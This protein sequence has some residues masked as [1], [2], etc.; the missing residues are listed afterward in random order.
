MKPVRTSRPAMM[1][2]FSPGFVNRVF[3]DFWGNDD[4][5]MPQ[6]SEFK[7][8]SEIIKTDSGYQVRVSLPGVKKDDMK[9]DLDG[10]LLTLSGER[11]SEHTENK[12]NVVRSEINYGRFSR[13]FT[14]TS[15]IDRSKIQADYADGMLT[16][17]LPVSEKATA[18]R[19]DI[20]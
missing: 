10:N 5:F 19:I 20:K 16:I 1:D 9:I 15:D 12:N 7:P 17:D 6:L 14:L 3:S 18:Q 4:E 13:S 8:S 2:V 11:R